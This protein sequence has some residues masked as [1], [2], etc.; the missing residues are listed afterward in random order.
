MDKDMRELFI[1]WVSML[2]VF[3]VFAIGGFIVGYATRCSLW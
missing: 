3:A 2:I 1:I